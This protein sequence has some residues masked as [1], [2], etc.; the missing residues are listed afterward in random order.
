MLKVQRAVSGTM[1]VATN[2]DTTQLAIGY[3]RD[4]NQVMVEDP[5]GSVI[6]NTFDPSIAQRCL[7]QGLVWILLSA[8]F[9]EL[10]E[11]HG[12]VLPGEVLPEEVF[13]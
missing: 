6:V 13:L 9:I 3:D 11:R 10:K 1:R 5:N 12:A 7:A 2:A 4:S 8:E